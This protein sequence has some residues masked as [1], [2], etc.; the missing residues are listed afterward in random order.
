MKGNIT[1]KEYERVIFDSDSYTYDDAKKFLVEDQGIENPTDDEIQ[2]EIFDC[3]EI[4]FK[5]ERME[6]HCAGL[7]CD[8]KL[9]G[10]ADM[11][12][13]NGRKYGYR[14]YDSFEDI[15]DRCAEYDSFKLYIDRGNLRA[16]LHHHDGTHYVIFREIPPHIDPEKLENA[17]LDDR[18]QKDEYRVLKNYS[19]SLRKYF[20]GYLY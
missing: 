7:K 13:W 18:L 20:K 14:E 1:M 11:G 16:I 17:I 3:Q 9:V 19:R 2:Q 8:G 10:I 12:L 15:L 4:W 6:M 5:D